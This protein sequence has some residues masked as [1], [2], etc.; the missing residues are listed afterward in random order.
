M[1]KSDRRFSIRSPGSTRGT[2]LTILH[3]RRFS[4]KKLEKLVPQGGTK[5]SLWNVSPPRWP[6][7]PDAKFRPEEMALLIQRMYDFSQER[8]HLVLWMPAYELHQTMLQPIDDLGMW[9]SQA[10]IFSG[11]NKGMKIGYVFA[12]GP[13]PI[14]WENIILPDTRQGSR[15]SIAM[16]FLIQK[17]LGKQ[18][19]AWVYDTRRIVEPFMSGSAELALWARRSGIHYI[20]YTGSKKVFERVKEKLAQHELP[21]IQ[22]RLPAT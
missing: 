19:D 22:M 10:T 7:T 18:P 15:S 20:G 17:L 21:G 8:A 4:I 5:V 14:D 16:R 3:R 9:C 11:S 2:E 13:T 6:G 12:R 1:K